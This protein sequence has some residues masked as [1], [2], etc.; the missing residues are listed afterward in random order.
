MQPPTT[1]DLELES[2]K[3]LL[4]EIGRQRS[5]KELLWLIVRRLANQPAVALARIWLMEEGDICSTCL[6]KPECPDQSRCLH[7]VAS[8]GHSANVHG[9]QWSRLDGEFRRFPL[10]VRKVGQIGKTGQPIVLKEIEEG[11][12]WIANPH[13]VKEESIRGFHG[14][15]IVYQM[16]S[17]ESSRFFPAPSA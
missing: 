14:Q 16:R 11:S 15:P 8:E 3:S 13:W 5:L 10:G 4:L 9:K 17:W 1:L 6:M 2:F 7:L 12:K